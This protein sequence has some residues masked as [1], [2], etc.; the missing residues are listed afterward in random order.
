VGA[1]M[2][3]GLALHAPSI[4]ALQPIN[5]PVLLRL[6]GGSEHDGGG[7]Q[8]EGSNMTQACPSQTTKHYC[9][10]TFLDP[11]R[12]LMPDGASTTIETIIN[13]VFIGEN[14]Q[15]DQA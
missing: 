6:C 14:I 12:P 1:K 10:Y 9:N 7:P 3:L 13:I 15:L 8:L 11:L 2:L 5:M 4:L